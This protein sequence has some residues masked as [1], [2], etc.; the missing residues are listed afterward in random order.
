M[1]DRVRAGKEANNVCAGAK[2][3]Q[4]QKTGFLS[5]VSEDSLTGYSARPSPQNRKQMQRVLGDTPTISLSTTL[6]ETVGQKRD[7]TQH[8]RADQTHDEV[9]LHIRRYSRFVPTQHNLRGSSIQEKKN[10][11][12][13]RKRPPHRSRTRQ[14]S[15]KRKRKEY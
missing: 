10:G 15:L 8:E 2:P 3:E 7:H 13:R 14:H 4:N 12:V 6:V 5:L 1:G 11:I 9:N